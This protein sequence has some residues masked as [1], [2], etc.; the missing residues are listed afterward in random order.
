MQSRNK[1]KVESYLLNQLVI[2]E[3]KSTPNPRL[4]SADIWGQGDPR[5]Q[6]MVSNNFHGFLL[7]HKHPDSRWFLVPESLVESLLSLLSG[8]ARFIPSSLKI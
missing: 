8:N 5:I 2:G 3:I 7:S 4:I 6:E 1:W